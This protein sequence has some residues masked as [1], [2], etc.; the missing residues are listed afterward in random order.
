MPDRLPEA[1]PEDKGMID[2]GRHFIAKPFSPKELIDKVR[3]AL[4]EKP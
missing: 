1:F 2:L 3:E 4:D